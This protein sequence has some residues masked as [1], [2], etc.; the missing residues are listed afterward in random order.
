MLGLLT[1]FAYFAGSFLEISPAAPPSKD[2]GVTMAFLVLA[3][4]QLVQAYNCRGSAPVL[5]RG[6]FANKALNI[7]ALCSFAFILLI[8]LVPP[9]AGVFSLSGVSAA[10]W[11]IA[12][13]LSLVPLPITEL[14][15]HFRLRRSI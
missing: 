2:I 5:R 4:S 10:H 8:G 3:F 1:L 13:G 14:V 6:L 9:L 12:A 11:L 15:K 7:A